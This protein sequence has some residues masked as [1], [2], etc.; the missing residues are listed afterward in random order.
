LAR[1]TEITLHLKED[2]LEYTDPY[3][4]KSLAQHY[5]EFIMYPISLRTVHTIEV[6]DDENVDE[7]KDDAS[8][9]DDL[10]VTDEEEADKPK[11]MK[12]VTSYEWERLNRNQAIWTRDKDEISDDEYQAFF[13][14]SLTKPELLAAMFAFL[15]FLWLGSRRYSPAASFRMHQRGYTLMRKEILTSSQSCTSRKTSPLPIV[16]ATLRLWLAP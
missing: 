11:K 3:R 8:K 6:E 7:A 10:E 9:S 15:T 14:V 5:S 4:L 16:T 13:H 12:E 1:G 2:A